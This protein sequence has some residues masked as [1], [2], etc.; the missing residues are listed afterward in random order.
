MAALGLSLGLLA[1]GTAIAGGAP[2]QA[3]AGPARWVGTW[4][5][6]P[7]GAVRPPCHQCTIRN[8]VHVSVG[9]ATTRVRLSND[10]GTAP[11]RV[12]HATLAL[13]L[14]ADSA[15]VRAGSLRQ[16]T[17]GGQP[18]VLI[19]PGQHVFSD[20]TSLP[21]AAGTD[22]SVTTYLPDADPLLTRHTIAQ[23]VSY[24]ADGPDQANAME[25]IYFLGTTTSFWVVTGVDV[26]A[27]PAAGAV[28]TLGDSITDGV[29]SQYNRNLRWPDDLS[30]RMATL[31]PGRR[32]GVLNTGIAGNR[33]LLDNDANFGPSAL[34]RFDLDVA[35]QTGART[36]VILLGINDINQQPPQHD[37]AKI[38]AGL[39]TLAQRAHQ[40]G[41]RVVGA[42]LTPYQGWFQYTPQGEQTRQAVNDWIRHTKVFDSFVDF[43]AALRDPANPHRMLPRWDSGDHLHPGNA[44]Y[45]RMADVVDLNALLR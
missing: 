22:L 38:A 42:T 7:A 41:L 29:E 9:G 6:A 34:H 10:Y 19:P 20:P 44:G 31:P 21:V 36:V 17:F 13:S 39:T 14:D 11:L 16:L 35:D 37:P 8:V 43:D 33:I 27:A 23:Q 30:R 5:T 40:H 2:S 18:S 45:Q 1:W 3:A 25:S 12:G 26:T 32:L 4:A 24:Y 15:G 28:V